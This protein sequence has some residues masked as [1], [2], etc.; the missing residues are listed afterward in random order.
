MQNL[1]KGEHHGVDM[2]ALFIPRPGHKFVI[3][4]LSQIETRV[5]LYLAGDTT[6]LEEI[7]KG[8]SPYEAHARASMG[9]TGGKLKEEDPGLYALAKARVLGLGF[10]CGK[11]RFSDLAKSMVGIELTPE[12]AMEGQTFS[13]RQGVNFGLVDGCADTLAAV[14]EKLR[15]RHG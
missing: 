9:W 15:Q 4:D 3:S 5:L 6:Q 14:Q 2:R 7:A 8:T 1:H 11:V 12:E 10:G 13:G